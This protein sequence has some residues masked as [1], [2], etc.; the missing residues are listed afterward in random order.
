MQNIPVRDELGREIRKMFEAENDGFILI[1]ADYS[2]IELRVLAHASGDETMQNAFKNGEDIHRQTA[3]SIF[4]V[5][6]DEVTD[7]MRS[8]AKTIN[9]G[10]IYGMGGYTLA[11]DLKISNK[12]AKAYID[13]YFEKFSKVKEYMNTTVE[14]SK[15]TGYVTTLFGRRRYIPELK[16]TNHMVRSFGERA[17]MNTP[18]QG[19]AADI[20][21]IAMVS[22]Y[23]KLKQSNLK[24]KLILQ[25]HDELIIQAP[26]AEEQIVK[27]LLTDCMENAVNL[28]VPLIA[29]ANTG[30][31]WYDAK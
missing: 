17:A 15:E 10:I 13:S 3:S 18:I 24:S 5:S 21:K 2:Q 29:E 4:G 14:N 28:N 11:Q 8:H 23:S 26:K 19:S 6:A 16:S 1:D 12:E 20:I 31:T 30:K 27:K 9:F 7:T 22:I 25:V